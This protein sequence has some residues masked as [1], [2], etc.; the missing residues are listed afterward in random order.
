M[1]TLRWT[2]LFALSLSVIPCVYAQD[3]EDEDLASGLTNNLNQEVL[4]HVTEHLSTTQAET[5]RPQNNSKTEAYINP[6]RTHVYFLCTGTKEK[7][8]VAIPIETLEQIPMLSRLVKSEIPTRTLTTED[9]QKTCIF[10]S[11]IDSRRLKRIVRK[12][13]LSGKE[14]EDYL[15]VKCEK[16]DIYELDIK[17]HYQN[18]DYY[19]CNLCDGYG[20]DWGL[21][22][23]AKHLKK[24][25]PSVEILF[26]KSPHKHFCVR[27]TDSDVLKYML[28]HRSESL[29]VHDAKNE[30]K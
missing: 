5:T 23:L 19:I 27:F 8:V 29:R 17:H 1:K 14:T 4:V 12:V 28:E 25:H 20:R 26:S 3:S 15:G 9:T 11:N 18:R 10:L 7:D 6:Q 2:L 22:D 24:I 16:T 30:K 21:F 13:Q